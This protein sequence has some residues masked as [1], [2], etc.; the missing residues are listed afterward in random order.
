MILPF[1]LHPTADCLIVKSATLQ[2][3]PLLHDPRYAQPQ[4]RTVFGNY[5]TPLFQTNCVVL[6]F[7]TTR[8]L[9]SHFQ[10]YQTFHLSPLPPHLVTVT[11]HH[12]VFAFSV[13]ALL[14]FGKS[15]FF[16]RAFPF[17][18][19]FLIF[20]VLFCKSFSDL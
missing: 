11:Y 5:V 20:F 8:K 10:K 17:L 9:S 19:F 1:V 12:F 16:V 14:L 7:S 3:I 13:F 6:V 18:G 4:A 15:F 2:I